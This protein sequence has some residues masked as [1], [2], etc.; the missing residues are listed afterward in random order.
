MSVAPVVAEPTQKKEGDEFD[1]DAAV[2]QATA[3]ALKATQEKREKEIQRLRSRV[4]QTLADLEV[5]EK[6]TI[7]TIWYHKS[8]HEEV[9]QLMAAVTARGNAC[10]TWPCK[11]DK[12]ELLISR[13]GEPMPK[14]YGCNLL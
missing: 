14:Y 12:I 7:L 5:A 2:R 6:G 10:T 13:R 3:V 8:L 11:D 1:L 4:A 9:I